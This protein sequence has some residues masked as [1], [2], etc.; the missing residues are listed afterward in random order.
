MECRDEFFVKGESLPTTFLRDLNVLAGKAHK[1]VDNS[2]NRLRVRS[3][4]LIAHKEITD[5]PRR[6][7]IIQMETSCRANRSINSSHQHRS[8]LSYT[9]EIISL[10]RA[11]IQE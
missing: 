2:S 7:N 9:L 4:P 8:D 1:E 3:L 6:D 11:L 10:Y 5:H